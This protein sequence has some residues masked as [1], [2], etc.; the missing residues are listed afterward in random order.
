MRAVVEVDAVVRVQVDEL[1]ALVDVLAD[2]AVGVLER[3][4]HHQDRRADV[5]PEALLLEH[6]AAAA[7]PRLLFDDGHVEPELAQPQRRG[8]PAHPRADDND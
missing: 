3:F 6:V 8:Q 7:R 5:H 1:D 2:G 4:L